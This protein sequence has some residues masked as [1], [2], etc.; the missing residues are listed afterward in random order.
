MD[1]RGT[2]DETGLGALG[3]LDLDRVDLA[4]RPRRQ[5]R[6][7][8][9]PPDELRAWEVE[10]ER[11][12]F[13]R[14]FPPNVTLEPRGMD[15]E[16]WTSPHSDPALW[17]LQLADAF[18]TRSQA[19]L[20]LF[21]Y[22]LQEMCGKGVWDDE[23]HQWRMSEAEVSAM[24]ALVNAHKPKN[25]REA[26]HAAQLVGMHILSMKVIARAI[27]Y[28]YD[29]RTVGNVAKLAAATA[30]LN[31]SLDEIKGR[32]RTARQ[33]IKVTKETHIHAHKHEHQHAGGSARNDGRPHGRKDSIAA[34]IDDQCA[35]VRCED[36]GRNLLSLSGHKGAVPLQTARRQVGGNDG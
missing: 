3:D 14:P 12:M 9:D 7:R 25:E 16:A 28:P 13:A 15:Q 20:N 17:T 33:T 11:R 21:L 8:P 27:K 10:A 24:L 26:M 32:K 31:R 6:N 5:A 19:V 34:Q 22:Q 29:S 30:D 36:K 35:S 4:R 1:K 23:A 18:G 2:N